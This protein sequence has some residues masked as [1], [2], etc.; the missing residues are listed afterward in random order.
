MNA[1]RRL[2]IWTA[3]AAGLVVSFMSCA[4][5]SSAM[6][7]SSDTAVGPT[8]DAPAG[9][10]EGRIEGTLR[11]FKGIPYASP[12]T[13]PGRWKPPSPLPRWT[14]IR[15]ATT[16]GPACPQ[17]SRRIVSVYMEEP[18]PTSEDC[19]TLNIW[20]PEDVRKAPVIV[21]IH[22]GAFTTGAGGLPYY[23]GAGLAAKGMVVVSINYRLGVLGYLAH[24]DLSAESARGVSG[25]YGLLDQIEALRWV[26]RN[27]DAFGGD[28]ANVTV[29]G[30]SSGGLSVVYL[31]ASPDAHGLFAKAIAQSAYMI[32]T[33]ELKDSRFG[34]PSAEE[35]G[36]H[37]AAKLNAAG[38]SA[39]RA[40][41]AQNLVDAAAAA[42]YAAFGTV[43]GKV[44]P[45]Q[46]IDV[47][48]R[49]EQAAVPV[50]AGFNRGEIRSLK[51]LTP[52]PP[53]T[54]ADY[55][56][57]IRERY[58]DLSDEFLRL[59][60]AT[61]LQES[62]WATTRDALYGWTAERLVR[63][64][65]ALGVPAYL[66]LFDHGYPAAD[67][68]GLHAFHASELPYEFGTL[69]RTPALWPKIPAT[70]EER[71]FSQAMMDYWSSFARTSRPVALH[72]PDWPAYGA[73][74]G[75]MLLADV[76]RASRDLFPGMYA[77]QEAAVC[78]RRASDEAW[79][80]NVGIISPRL[81]NKAARC[82]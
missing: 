68:A 74:H 80:W 56:R 5:P 54:A 39:L 19:L 18:G 76:P 6:P 66:Y 21:W 69:D 36:T 35:I 78:R 70:S 7:A 28:P 65:T 82:P 15:T 72:E 50:L 71:K 48:D 81:D 2:K 4:E 38:I 32:S 11:V 25:N 20:T 49:G 26:Q 67:S 59:Y 75:Y 46:L 44:L 60:P 77:L 63:N 43:D 45:R 47:F 41:D 29:A 53:A 3:G 79:N 30:E 8:I 1:H 58:L 52:P 10:I 73:D 9:Q 37:L 14:G 13:G 40:M 12:P 16:F 23:D 17:P 42:G 31:M 62:M 22:G 27:I 61:D 64:Q 51:F 34:S 57:I 33:P 24:P 55:E